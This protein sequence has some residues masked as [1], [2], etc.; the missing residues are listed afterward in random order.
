MRSYLLKNGTVVNEGLSKRQDVLIKNNRIDKIGQDISD[1]TA[2]IIDLT[3]KL[4]LPG[5]IDDQV[6]FREP[7]LTHKA[8]IGSESKAAIA[9]GITSEMKCN[10][11]G[12]YNQLTTT[13]LATQ[14]ALHHPSRYWIASVSSRYSCSHMALHSACSCE[15][16]VFCL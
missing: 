8:N 13:L 12:Q 7:G 11:L 1:S 10:Y 16:L 15:G 9:G 4:I 3:N 2:I 5:C 14:N 6:H